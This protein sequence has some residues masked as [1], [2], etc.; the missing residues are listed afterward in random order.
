MNEISIIS[1]EDALKITPNYYK[2]S[3]EYVYKSALLPGESV[4]FICETTR[5]S[6]KEER[7]WSD[8]LGEYRTK[9]DYF[10]TASLLLITNMRWIRKPAG[11]SQEEGLLFGEKSQKERFL[12]TMKSGYRWARPIRDDPPSEK[13]AERKGQSL[14]EWAM[15]NIRFLSLGKIVLGPKKIRFTNTKDSQ[16]TYLLVKITDAHYSFHFE[17]GE[18]VY[19]IVQTALANNGK[20]NLGASTTGTSTGGESASE[21]PDGNSIAAR[22][23]KLK[24]L[25]AAELITDE[26]YEQKRQQILDT[27]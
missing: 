12:K 19:H 22:L 6:I 26:E 16:D 17:Q 11:W 21:S 5:H 7:N 1:L 4:V 2:P 27:L 18:T 24:E 23:Q 25:L 8:L 10:N 14:E 15:S 3:V 9:R 13:S 20:L